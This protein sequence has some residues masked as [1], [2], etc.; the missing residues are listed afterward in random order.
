MAERDASELSIK[1]AE[2]VAVVKGKTRKLE[3]K[4]DGWMGLLTT[5]QGIAGLTA[6]IIALGGLVAQFTGKAPP[7]DRDTIIKVEIVKGNMT[8]EHVDG[9]APL[10]AVPA[11]AFGIVTFSD[12]IPPLS[13]TF[14]DKYRAK[15]YKIEHYALDGQEAIAWDAL[16]KKSGGAPCLIVT[17]TK[18]YL[19]GAALVDEA[20]AAKTI[21]KWEK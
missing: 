17:D 20:A 15:G 5:K 8:V 7:L 14:W 10:P 6:I 16:I 2:E 9:P 13:Q 3:E 1:N 4:V 11:K 19:G 18:N 21:S 12:K